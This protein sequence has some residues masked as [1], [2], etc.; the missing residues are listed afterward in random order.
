M[1]LGQQAR[2]GTWNHCPHLF[3]L[4]NLLVVAETFI[5]L[6]CPFS[7]YDLM[8]SLATTDCIFYLFIFFALAYFLPSAQHKT[9]YSEAGCLYVGI[10]S[11]I[12]ASLTPTRRHL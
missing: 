11:S 10:Q 9:Q 6:Q 3:M 12:K 7:I 1:E 2:D 4:A 5:K 8:A